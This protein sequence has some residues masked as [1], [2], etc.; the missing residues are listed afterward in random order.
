MNPRRPNG[1]GHPSG[2]QVLNEVFNG[3]L[4]RSEVVRFVGN[5]LIYLDLRGFRHGTLTL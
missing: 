2:S 1:L 5:V 4:E 3:V